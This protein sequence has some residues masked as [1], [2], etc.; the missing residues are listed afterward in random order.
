MD[1][2]VGPAPRP[3]AEE[4]TQFAQGAQAFLE[5]PPVEVLLE[6]RPV[7]WLRLTH[8]TITCPLSTT[9]VWPVMQRA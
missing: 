1:V 9:R 6:R 3:W 4:R 2:R 5:R 8:R 7:S